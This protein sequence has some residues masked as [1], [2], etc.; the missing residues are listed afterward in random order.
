VGF[1]YVVGHG[2][3][4]ALMEEAFAGA[5]A[6]FA[7]PAEQKHALRA[8]VATNNRGYTE[9]GEETLD[10][11]RQSRGDT[12]AR[13]E[14]FCSRSRL[15]ACLTPSLSQEGYYIGREVPADSPEAALPL[16]GARVQRM[17]AFLRA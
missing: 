1:F 8:S 10:P 15:S 4:G 5:R 11:G 3:E 12:K 14:A 6:L 13:A 16:H 2:V 7:L 9:M 17:R